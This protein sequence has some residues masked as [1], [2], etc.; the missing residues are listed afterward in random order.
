MTTTPSSRRISPASAWFSARMYESSAVHVPQG[1]THVRRQ[2]APIREGALPREGGRAIDHRSRLTLRRG[3]VV[4][5]HAGSEAEERVLLAPLREL[6]RLAVLRGITFVV[7]AE[8]VREALEQR[9]A[10]RERDRATDHAARAEQP[11]LAVDEMHRAALAAAEPVA[12]AHHLGEHASGIGATREEVAV[13]AVARVD[14]IARAKGVHHSDRD[15]LLADRKM[16]EPRDLARA[17]ELGDALLEGAE[18]PH[19][20]EERA[21]D[22]SGAGGRRPPT[23][24]T[25]ARSRAARHRRS[26]GT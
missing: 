17:D 9:G 7:A 8:S 13:R 19:A 11:V 5:A 1:V 16:D 12:A 18:Q 22:R 15:R 20:P 23:A 2:L 21:T 26:R 25:R 6:G 3:R 4:R 14:D 24:S 10:E